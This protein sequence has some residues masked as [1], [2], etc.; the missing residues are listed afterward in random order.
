MKKQIFK[1]S[2]VAMVTPMNEDKSINY[3]VLGDLI[4]FQIKFGTDAIISCGTTGEA[5][6]MTD[7][8]RINVIKYTVNKVG[9]RVP[10]IAGTGSNNTAHAIELSKE[11]EHLGVD[12]ILVVT[13]YY[14]KTSQMGLVEHYSHIADSVDVPMILYNVPSRTGCNILPET[15]LK[16]SRH[17]GIV[18][19]KE[20]NGNISSVIETR[21]LCGDDLHIYSGNDDQTIPIMS[22][23]GIGVI[24]VFANICPDVSSKITSNF[25]AGQYNESL[26]LLLS[27]ERL[28]NV[29]FSDVNPIPVKAALNLM[30]YNCGKCRLP[31]VDMSD[32]GLKILESVLKEYNLV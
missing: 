23:G 4:E 28:M 2:G 7:Y 24:S 1:G 31:L 5:S 27:Y 13:P 8:E 22:L 14:N 16:L 26:D 6:T 29:L 18:A 32:N 11:A 15:Y 21:S 17:P 25:F 20:A 12:G 10:V 30:G 9:G 3:D 19:T